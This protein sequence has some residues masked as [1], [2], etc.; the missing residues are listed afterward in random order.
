MVTKKTEK[1]LIDRIKELEAENRKLKLEIKKLKTNKEGYYTLKNQFDS[2]VDLGEFT[3]SLPPLIPDH[4]KW[5]A[6]D[7]P[8]DWSPEQKAH[9]YLMTFWK[10]YPVSQS[11]F[12]NV[13]G[14]QSFY[15]YLKRNDLFK[16]LP[17]SF[18]LELKKRLNKLK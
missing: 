15:K 9:D 1:E 3:N 11:F 10:N 18:Q 14:G 5:S 4:K 12:S 7:Y 2:S 17:D 16:L 8:N 13:R 6:N